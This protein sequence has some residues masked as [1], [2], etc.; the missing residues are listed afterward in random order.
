MSISNS[1]LGFEPE[2]PGDVKNWSA[3]DF[4]NFFIRFRP[5]IERHAAKYLR[6]KSMVDE[7]VQEAFL[8]LMIALP[9]LDSELGVLRFLKWKV[10]LLCLDV[11]RVSK[12]NIT[13]VEELLDE[14][15]EAEPSEDIIRADDA[16]IVQLA[17]SKI[18]SRQREALIASIYQEKSAAQISKQLGI[19]ENA[20]R[21][22]LLRARTSLKKALVGEADLEGLSLAEIISVAARKAAQ[23]SRKA[24]ARA[25]GAVLVLGLAAFALYSGQVSPITGSQNVASEAPS[26]VA[27]PPSGAEAE[28]SASPLESEQ[29]LPAPSDAEISSENETSLATTIEQDPVGE[30]EQVLEPET[31]PAF[32]TSETLLASQENVDR[33]PFDPWLVD[34]IFEDSYS[35]DFTRLPSESVT[36][37]TSRN[38]YTVAVSA[39]VWADIVF[40]PISAEPFSSVQIG[41]VAG[42]EQYFAELEA[43]DFLVRQDGSFEIFSYFGA[44]GEIIDVRGDAHEDSRMAGTVFEVTVTFDPTINQ[45]VGLSLN[46]SDQL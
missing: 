5:Q 12:S 41:F 10:R 46:R 36:S 1:D 37:S 15:I 6:D 44:V 31:V 8:Y 23:E 7:V 43:E 34:G 3:Q 18:D 16:A 9:E 39:G 38:I 29:P 20:T 26:I 22:L 45:V 4:S 28:V 19:S 21:Q 17:L 27:Q 25:M 14:K 40:D 11:I 13:G 35:V 2:L 24:G 30:P 33:S 32:S 42:S